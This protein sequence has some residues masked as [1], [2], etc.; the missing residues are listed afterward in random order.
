MGAIFSTL[1]DEIDMKT[2]NALATDA[3]PELFF[4]YC[5]ENGRISKETLL[6][7]AT[8]ADAFF[9]HDWE[10]DSQGRDNHARVR[11]IQQL[12]HEKQVVCWLDEDH[13]FG[14]VFE[15]TK[16]AV[17]NS[18][19]VVVFIT[20][21][22]IKKVNGKHS[23]DNCKLEY[24]CATHRRGA[25]K[26]IPVVMEPEMRNPDSWIGPV[27]Y[28]LGGL[29]YVDC[30]SDDNLEEM[31]EILYQEIKKRVGR[32]L[33]EAANPMYYQSVHTQSQPVAVCSPHR[34]VRPA[35]PPP[36]SPSTTLT[37]NLGGNKLVSLSQNEVNLIL[38]DDHFQLNLYTDRNSYSA[39]GMSRIILPLP[40]RN[41]ASQACGVKLPPHFPCPTHL[42]Y[43]CQ[44]PTMC[45]IYLNALSE[46]FVV[47]LN[48]IGEIMSHE[49]MPS[50]PATT[51][52]PFPCHVARQVGLILFQNTLYYF[53]LHASTGEIGF[54]QSRDGSFPA[55][56][57]PQGI[58]KLPN[59]QSIQTQHFSLCLFRNE[60][61]LLQVDVN[62]VVWIRSFASPKDLLPPSTSSQFSSSQTLSSINT[63]PSSGYS[64]RLPNLS[65]KGIVK[66][67]LAA[68]PQNARLTILSMDRDTEIYLIPS[69]TLPN[70]MS[71]SFNNEQP[72]IDEEEAIHLSHWHGKYVASVYCPNTGKYCCLHIGCDSHVYCAIFQQGC[73]V[74]GGMD[75][76]QLRQ[77]KS[78]QIHSLV[79]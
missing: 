19:C 1:P 73:E 5:N 71:T 38:C 50:T 4:Q 65:T 13:L 47:L 31:V 72:E 70:K 20:A 55:A 43:L 36:V 12:L 18:T 40:Y 76:F 56:R 14:N 9:S 52:S 16:R 69:V 51:T 74:H 66:A 15:K 28:R 60:L 27:G 53:F 29:E 22:Y 45:I 75:F 26:M 59:P 25:E 7:L 44:K 64:L 21:N 23:H 68:A 34:P 41:T 35:Q 39:D 2:F 58:M 6:R 8:S 57:T 42:S 11:K 46:V 79:G 48:D 67:S 77:V 3:T 63:T 37:S 33:K 78:A 54:V 32:F 30:S 10:E 24:N 49:P 17:N 61:Y 62:N